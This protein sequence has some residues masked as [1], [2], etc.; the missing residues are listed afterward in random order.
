MKF[1]HI[2]PSATILTVVRTVFYRRDKNTVP[3]TTMKTQSVVTPCI[4]QKND[5]RCYV[6][7]NKSLTYGSANQP[8]SSRALAH[9]R[10]G[11]RSGMVLT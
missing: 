11:R 1:L 5:L 9:R 7:L 8:A 3:T 2:D 10:C 6:Y 4:M